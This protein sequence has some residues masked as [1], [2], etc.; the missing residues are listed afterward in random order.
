MVAAFELR[1]RARSK[2]A[3]R[4]QTI[5]RL[6]AALMH[7]N[8]IVFWNVRKGVDSY[9]RAVMN[10]AADRVRRHALK[11]VGSAY[12]NVDVRWIVEGCTGDKESWSWEKLVDV[13]RLG[14]QKEDD[15]II[16]R[17]PKRRPEKKL[18]PIKETAS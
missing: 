9:M 12:L 2:H 10:W 7:D 6:L 8:W 17:R 1:A 4:S 13:E 14:W 11:A 5:D 18:D 3:I 16:I 15:K